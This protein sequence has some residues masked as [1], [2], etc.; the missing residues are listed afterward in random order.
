M[1]EPIEL[2][3]DSGVKTKISA[4][5]GVCAF[6]IY[7]TNSY[8]ASIHNQDTANLRQQC[9]Q[10]KF[11]EKLGDL[12]EGID[13]VNTRLNTKTERTDDAVKELTS[14]MRDHVSGHYGIQ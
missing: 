8:T 7:V 14:L 11:D 6:L 12:L 13:G 2:T 9:L 5:L 10:E 3:R 4:I 1:S